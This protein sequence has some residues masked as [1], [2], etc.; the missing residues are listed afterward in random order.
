M[1]EETREE[2]QARQAA[3]NKVLAEAI[4]Q[5]KPRTLTLTMT[6]K[7]EMDLLFYLER[8]IS[9]DETYGAEKMIPRVV[10]DIRDALNLAVGGKTVDYQGGVAGGEEAAETD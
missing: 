6:N 1:S 8:A 10:K 7:E 9:V 5:L 3:D 2:I 4:A